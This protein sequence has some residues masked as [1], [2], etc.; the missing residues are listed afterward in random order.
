MVDRLV[1]FFLEL[2]FGGCE[3]VIE[4]RR[5]RQPVGARDRQPMRSGLQRHREA[6]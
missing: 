6:P 4:A 2:Q 3:R 1:R 5:L